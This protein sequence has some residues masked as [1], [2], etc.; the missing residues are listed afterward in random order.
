MLFRLSCAPASR[1]MW[2]GISRAREGE[3]SCQEHLVSR[4]W[5]PLASSLTVPQKNSAHQL[6]FCTTS[7][8]LQPAFYG[9][10][11]SRV[12]RPRPTRHNPTQPEVRATYQGVD[13][14]FCS[15]FTLVE[16]VYVC[17]LLEEI[18]HSYGH[19]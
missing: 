2:G 16:G 12:A 10:P 7:I 4:H 1:R 11:L 14:N 18:D 9:C 15:F 6:H 5:V 13:E 17:Q 3:K 19:M 8:Q